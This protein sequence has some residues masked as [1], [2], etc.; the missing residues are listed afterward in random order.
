MF[1]SGQEASVVSYDQ[2]ERLQVEVAYPDFIDQDQ[3]LYDSIK[4]SMMLQYLDYPSEFHYAGY[5]I[6]ELAGTLLNQYGK[7]FQQGFIDQEIIPSSLYQGFIYGTAN[8]NQLVP[9]VTLRDR[10]IKSVNKPYIRLDED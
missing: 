7:Y 8:D 10:R 9:I 1:T 5:Q 6:V 3:P 4:T 2:L